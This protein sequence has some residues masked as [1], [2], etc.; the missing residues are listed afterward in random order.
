V[1]RHRSRPAQAQ[2]QRLV[3]WTYGLRAA[4]GQHGTRQRTLQ[5][6]TKFGQLV[7]GERCRCA[8][9]SAVRGWRWVRCRVRRQVGAVVGRVDIRADALGEC[10]GQQLR[11]GALHRL[12]A[13]RQS[14]RQQAGLAQQNHADQQ[15]R[16]QH[17]DQRETALRSLSDETRH[18]RLTTLRSGRR[19]EAHARD[20]RS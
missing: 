12:T 4:H 18:G 14:C 13:A 20:R 1:A 3:G 6:M 17:L 16:D 5:L 11:L 2:L 8:G 15:A 9:L 7:V 19:P 10:A